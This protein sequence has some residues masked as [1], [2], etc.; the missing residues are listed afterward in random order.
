MQQEHA[1]QKILLI[2]TAFIG[3]LILTTP[4]VREIKKLY[5][6]SYLAVVINQGTEL[7]L[8]HNPYIDEVISLDKK[9]IKKSLRAFLQ[10]IG[11]LREYKFDICIAAHFSYRSSLL[12]FLSG[13]S[14]RIGYKQSGFSFLHTQKIERPLRGMHE[15]EKLFSLIYPE[16]QKPTDLQPE[17]HLVTEEMRDIAEKMRIDTLGEKSYVVLAPSSVWQ[18]KRMPLAKFKQFTEMLLS[19]SKQ[20]IVLIG[21]KGDFS[22][23][24]EISQV[25]PKRVLNYAGRTNLQELS[26]VIRFAFCVVSNDSSPIHFASAHNVPTLAIFGATVAGFGYTPL[27]SWNYISQVENLPCR[28]CGIHGGSR[29]PKKHFSCMEEQDLAEMLRQIQSIP[30]FH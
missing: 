27:S 11:K 26:Y 20:K 21:S 16:E 3:D 2:Q 18:T 28:P 10:F 1:I 4:L 30:G 13:A 7:I 6:N 24:E 12:S 29:C 17:L 22:L 14:T 15:V 5:P 8:A 23:A 9:K 19:V 25:D